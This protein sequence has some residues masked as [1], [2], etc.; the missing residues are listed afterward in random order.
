MDDFNL[1]AGAGT[2]PGEGAKATEPGTPATPQ[3]DGW[4]AIL[5]KE[6]REKYAEHL[7][8]YAKPK[9]LFDDFLQLKEK[10]GKAIFVPAEDADEE[11]KKAYRTAL[12]VPADGKYKLAALTDEEKTLVGDAESF[13]QWFT[14]AAAKTELTQ[15]QAESFYRLYLTANVERARERA[16]ADKREADSRTEALNKLWGSKAKENFELAKRAFAKYATPEF[17]SWCIKNKMDTHPEMV[18]VFHNIAIRTADDRGTSST[19]GGKQKERKGL[20]YDS[21]NKLYPPEE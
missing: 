18:Q 10:V 5:P 1:T 3:G 4:T 20:H 6:Y 12:G 14:E 19:I 21:L 17:V 16:E 11:T 15:A 7:K 9:D 8:G 2:E 13:S